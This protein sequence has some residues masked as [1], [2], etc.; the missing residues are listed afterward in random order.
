RSGVLLVGS[1]LERAAGRQLDGVGGRDLDRG[2]S[3]GVA[4]LACGPAADAEC[5]E[6]GDADL[7]ALGGGGFERRLQATQ[8]GVHRLLLELGGVGDGGNQFLAVHGISLDRRWCLLA[9]SMGEGPQKPVFR[10]VP[11]SGV[12]R[13]VS[14]SGADG[15]KFTCSGR[16]S[17]PRRGV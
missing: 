17:G 16:V 2:A 10:G 8:D 13:R 9:S 5:E 7:L 15:A 6:A 4:A 11:R 12:S 14:V 1:V 3:G